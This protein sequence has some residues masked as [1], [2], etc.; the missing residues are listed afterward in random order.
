MI[1][2]LYGILKVGQ[3]IN[4]AF[5]SLTCWVNCHPLLA[6]KIIWYSDRLNV[7]KARF[8]PFF[9]LSKYC[10]KSCYNFYV[11]CLHVLP[12]QDCFC[13]VLFWPFK[14]YYLEGNSPWSQF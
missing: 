12:P 3:G 4:F 2:I 7:S 5:S 6:K 11:A 14:F 13:L 8:K 9:F 10:G 1:Y